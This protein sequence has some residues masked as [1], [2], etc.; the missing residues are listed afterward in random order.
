MP[1]LKPETTWPTTPEDSEIRRAIA[2]DPGTGE[3]STEDF[4]RMRP[5]SEIAPHLVAA[6]RQKQESKGN[7][8]KPQQHLQVIAGTPD[9]PLVISGVEMPCYVLEGERRVLSQTGML[10][11]MRLSYGGSPIRRGKHQALDPQSS[12]S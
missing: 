8:S 6:Y 11:G 1:K 2:D 9:H 7:T 3:L 5:A 4:E 12:G 10:K